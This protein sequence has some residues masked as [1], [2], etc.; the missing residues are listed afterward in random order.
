MAAEQ[1]PM[2]AGGRATEAGM[3][4]QA[5]VATW[6]AAH[7]LARIPVG[8]RFG[9]NNQAL[10]IAIRLE[11]GGALD[12]IEVSQSDGGA[13]YLQCKTTANLGTGPQSPLTKTIRQLAHWVA[14]AKAE[15]GLPDLARNAG[16][17]AV[18][19]NAP[20]TLDNLETGCR[21]FDLG[22]SW[23]ETRTQRNAAERDALIAFETIATPA[24]TTH[25]GIAP[26]HA[27]LVDLARIFHIARFT[28]DEGGSDWREASQLLG[29]RLF[30]DAAAGDAVLR[31]LKGIMRELI[32]S[33]APADRAGLLGALR[34]LGHQD[35]SAPGFEADIARLRE[36]T[37]RELARLAVHGR[38]PL[39]MGMPITR[40]SD[41]PLITA[42]RAGSLLV[43][44]EPG[45]GKTGALVHAAEAIEA[46][47]D[48]VVFLSVDR[49]PGVATA[50]DLESELRLTHPVIET[51]AAM[52][53]TGSKILI[54]DALDA[55]RGG[56]SEAVFA[57]LIESVREQLANDWIVI[58]SIRTFDLKNG[59]R[60]RRIFGGTP[61][62][63]EY[64]AAGLTTVRHFLIPRLS[65]SDL[66]AVGEASTELDALLGAASSQLTQLLRNIF[67]LSLAAQLLSDEIDP[68][69]FATIRTQAGL[70][71][72]Y[73]GAR[74]DTTQLQQAAGATVALMV[75]Q[76]RLSVRKI[77]IEHAELDEVI[78]S[79]VLAESGDLVSFAHHVL[80]DHVGGRFH[81]AWDD[82]N[83]LLDQLSGDTSTALLLAPALRFGIERLWRIDGEGRP[84]TW[85]LI[86]SI[87][88]ETSIDPVLGNI[89]LR[90]VVENIEDERDVVGLT[91][92]I[93]ESAIRPG[94]TALLG[95]LARFAAMDIEGGRTV[96]QAKAITWAR[97]AETLVVTDERSLIDPGFILLQ[98]LFNH[99]DLAAV[100]LDVFGRAARALLEF[101]W[102]TQPPLTS[103]CE[104]AIRFVG[105]SFA[106]DPAASRSLL[107][108]ILREPHFSQYADREAG[109][110]AEQIL[111][112][113]RA[114]P[115]FTVEIYAA[116]YG[117]MIT[118]SATTTWIGGGPPSRILP[119][120]SNRRQDYEHCWW[121]LGSA[122]GEVLTI[123][124]SY[125]T[126]AL[127]DSL[128]GK[129]RT[130]GY[131]SDR[132]PDVIKA[133]NTTIE[134]R[135]YEIEFNAWEEENGGRDRQ[136]DLLRHYVHFLRS[137]DAQIFVTSMNAASC[138]YATASVWT[139]IFGVGSERIDEVG[140]LLWPLIEEPDFLEHY[141]T[142]RDAIRFVE[143]AW[144]SRSSEARI[145]FETMALDETRFTD[146][147][148]LHRWHRILG[149]ILALVPEYMLE[150]EE[151]R[152]LRRRF[153]V[154]GLL[155]G[156]HPSHSYTHTWDDDHDFVREDLRRAGVNLDAGPDRNVF[157]ASEALSSF[158]KNTTSSSPMSELAALWNEATTLLNLIDQNP[159]LH[160]KVDEPAWGRVANA[161]ERIVSS[162]NYIPGMDGLPNLGAMFAV[163]ERLSSS[164]YPE[165]S[166]ADEGWHIGWGSWAV[167]VYAAQ[168]WVSLA[169][170]FAEEYPTIVDHIEAILEDP[171]PAVRLQAAQN[172]QVICIAAPERMWE[173]GKVIASQEANT[174]ILASYIRNSMWRFSHSEPMRCEEVL[175]I[176][177]GRLDGHLIEDHDGRDYLQ[178][179]LGSWTA[180][181]FS[182]QGRPLM[183]SWLDEWATDPERYGTLLNSYALSLRDAFFYRYAQHPEA[184]ACAMCNRAQ[185]GLTLILTRAIAL[186][187]E[188]HAILTSGDPVEAEKEAESKRYGA[189]EKVIHIAMNQLYF[190]SGA[191]KNDNEASPGLSDTAAMARFL[192]DYA[193]IL[194]LL[195]N[196]HEPA[197]HH[198]LIEL[199][200]FLIPGAPIAVFEA[201]YAVIFGSGRDEGYHYESLGN[202]AVVR[203]VQCYLADYRAVF[204]DVG[205][206]AKLVEMLQLFSDVGWTSALKLLYELP[207]ILR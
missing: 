72:A 69:A 173:M 59:R 22:G 38:L 10:P 196:S 156:N 34:Q 11:T 48:T 140:D 106:S 39:G 36:V 146:E 115:E 191:Y 73:E 7:I 70:I 51:L 190:G 54:I 19:A 24:W 30:G 79:G 178:E 9:I 201:I 176:V 21:A 32:G 100:L 149:R 80:F 91:A 189:A 44:G 110:L 192:S 99:G 113:T 83:A 127:I 175:A 47:G 14:D 198:H 133:G 2:R 45:A 82:P 52:P 63:G 50:A 107:D 88:S 75:S 65:E 193:D 141:G 96:D 92:Y 97:L 128:I 162:E 49:F 3:A 199:Y 118:D 121:Q 103:V 184:E 62:D 116:L 206:R 114:D 136:D 87:F 104:R 71:D 163:L 86:T 183:R 60:F 194:A 171:V 6:F 68:T 17:L 158:I 66:A 130:Q 117:Q 168:A 135:G 155:I 13:L 20:R 123:S 154:E 102:S 205:L 74:L 150:L 12:D 151:M 125:G 195:A 200:E 120:S 165:L 4:F 43:V 143:A 89:A 207:E 29:H 169:S 167:R 101:A 187:A 142:S 15:N 186:S 57:T 179:S 16:L 147:D 122:I 58:A 108:R 137:S 203:I 98:T 26:D 94:I 28:M 161:V 145:R 23:E 112:I 129:A 85:K 204:E 95:R 181:L 40:E 126:R 197:T 35:V 160:D 134:L 124:P 56:P 27:D 46:T 202:D 166:D 81:L 8:G 37:R 144:P 157:D 33:G 67:N 172:L 64:A 153:D 93:A 185:E 53:G 78:R 55:A 170:R 105:K 119:L 25:R 31:D 177:K 174:Q 109:W 159:G 148:E 164:R 182:G 42:I 180:Q 76:R 61:A 139:R 90:V 111:P 1:S 152:A 188:A 84:L 41:T 77:A 132:E 18:Q 138:E 131:G 5:A